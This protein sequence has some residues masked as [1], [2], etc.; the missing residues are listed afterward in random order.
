MN[1]PPPLPT[2]MSWFRALTAPTV[3]RRAAP[4]GLGVGLLQ[5]SLNQGDYWLHGT[6]TSAIVVKSLLS[7]LV[8]LS[9]AV[10]SAASVY[11]FDH[12]T[13]TSSRA[14]L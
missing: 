2:P 4:V 3:W 13:T 11:R 8:S 10:Y 1:I 6:V 9:L 12:T 14:A 7:P 5:M